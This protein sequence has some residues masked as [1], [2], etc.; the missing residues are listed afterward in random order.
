MT[1]ILAGLF[2]VAAPLAVL[3]ALAVAVKNFSDG[4]IASG[5]WMLIMSAVLAVVLLLPALFF[6]RHF[7]R[8]RKPLDLVIN[9]GGLGLL[10][11]EQ[12][13][14]HVPWENVT[15]VRLSTQRKGKAERLVVYT[16]PTSTSATSPEPGQR[17]WMDLPLSKMDG[18]RSALVEALRSYSRG[19]YGVGQ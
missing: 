3:V 1:L 6:W 10:E 13:L 15:S 9:G 18:E 11:G 2:V 5:V 16:G 14:R 4:S 7:L 19:R 17:V 8:K 12:I